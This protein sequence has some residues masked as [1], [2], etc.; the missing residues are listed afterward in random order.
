MIISVH[1]IFIILVPC[2]FFCPSKIKLVLALS[3]KTL[4]GHIASHVEEHRRRGIM[5]ENI[6]STKNSQGIHKEKGHIRLILQSFWIS[7]FT[8]SRSF[9]VK[10]CIING[11]G[12]ERK[13]NTINGKSFRRYVLHYLCMYRSIWFSR[14]VRNYFE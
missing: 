14:S 10:G 11:N 9:T 12:S 5:Q 3:K 8:T 4:L 7:F 6:K 1:L 13:K 2:I